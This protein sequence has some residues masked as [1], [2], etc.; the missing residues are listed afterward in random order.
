[1]KQFA[2][3]WPRYEMYLLALAQESL[4]QRCAFAMASPSTSTAYKVGGAFIM[5]C[6]PV[7]YTI[8]VY[9]TLQRKLVKEQRAHLVRKTKK[10]GGYLRW[11]DRPPPV[12]EALMRQK[13]Y[14]S[15]F[16][17]GYGKSFTAQHF[18]LLS[19][20]CSWVFVLAGCLFEDFTPK[21][22]DHAMPVLLLHRM[23]VGIGVGMTV[24]PTPTEAQINIV[25][26]SLLF[27]ALVVYIAI[28]QPF[29]VPMASHLH[30]I[31]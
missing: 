17:D 11:V 20:M 24:M 4:A 9:R 19:M 31:R 18:V 10:L 3:S 13:F 8:Y 2:F 7:A 23:L 30:T 22:I 28:A 15:G 5:L 21:S 12:E 1:M 26:L 16:V 29:I 25:A 27:L 6:W 14:F